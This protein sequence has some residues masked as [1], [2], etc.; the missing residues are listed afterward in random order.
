MPLCLGGNSAEL[1]DCC[2][3]MAILGAEHHPGCDLV[4]QNSTDG[5]ILLREHSV[6]QQERLQCSWGVCMKVLCS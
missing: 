3:I 4:S 1:G 5:S 6:E 2:S